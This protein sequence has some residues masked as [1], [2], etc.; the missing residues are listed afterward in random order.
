MPHGRCGLQ[1][2][3]AFGILACAPSPFGTICGRRQR[4]RAISLLSARFPERR[5]GVLY[6]KTMQTVQY[7]LQK[8]KRSSRW[9]MCSHMCSKG[10]HC[11][12]QKLVL[13][14]PNCTQH[15]CSLAQGIQSSFWIVSAS[16]GA[17]I[18]TSLGCVMGDPATKISFVFASA[19]LQVFVCCQV[20]SG[21][22]FGGYLEHFW[23]SRITVLSSF[24]WLFRSVLEVVALAILRGRWSTACVNM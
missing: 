7:I 20:V 13:D 22:A 4:V 1:L 23:V 5:S 21:D 18:W 11:V 19:S 6:C 8:S 2:G 15:P 16:V 12:S 10:I 17:R 14:I 9:R 3:G 24:E